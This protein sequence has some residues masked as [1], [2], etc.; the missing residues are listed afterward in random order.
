[1]G[2]K[3]ICIILAVAVFCGVLPF[4][5]FA[6][7][8]DINLV[9]GFEYTVETGEPI[10]QSYGELIIEGLEFNRDNG[11][12]TDSQTAQPTKGSDLWFRAYSG[13]SRI[14]SFD[15]GET[16]AV[17]G[18]EAGFLEDRA[19]DIFA[20][21]YIKIHLSSDGENYECVKEH[22][23]EYS[24][25]QDNKSVRH[26][27]KIPL[28]DIYAARFVR[29]EYSCDGFTYCDEIRVKGK[30]ELSGNEKTPKAKPSISMGG[31]TGD[32]NKYSDIVKLYNGFWAKDPSV[33]VL[34]ESELLPY[35]AYVNK[36]GE[37]LDKMFDGAILLP[38]D[39]VYPSGGRLYKND[40]APAIMSDYQLYIEQTFTSG[41]DLS[42]L[43]K[44]VGKVNDKLESDKKF[45][46]FLSV[47]YPCIT[48]VPFGD[49]NSDGIVDY[50][51]TLEDRLAI[52]K[53]YV[54][55]CISLFNENEYNNL[56]L[57]GF[58]WLEDKVDY[59]YSHHETQLL[60]K[61]N[62]YL[63]E[64]G[65][66]TLSSFGYL[67][68]GFDQWKDFGFDASVMKGEL[69]K[70]DLP[71]EMLPEFSRS[72]YNN[73]MGAEIETGALADYMEGEEAYLQLGNKYESYMYYGRKYGYSGAL[74][75]Y[76][77]DMA[78]GT[79][80]EFCYA[81]KS[82]PKGNYLRRLYDLTHNYINNNYINMPPS[83]S[84]ETQVE[85]LYGDNQ[86]NLDFEIK[87]IDSYTDDITVEF[88]IRPEHGNVVAAASKNKLIYS[89]D[90][91]FEGTDCFTVCVTDG[92]NRSE[93]VMVAVS[94]TKP[95]E[96]EEIIP[97]T[98]SAEP[99]PLG[100]N[101]EIPPWLLVVLL[102]LA[103]AMVGVAV[104]VI[105]KPKKEQND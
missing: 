60:I 99:L 80:Y 81:D 12:L 27:V 53:W 100:I 62:D 57:C 44:V 36:N 29:V 55:E 86:I 92:F 4:S 71:S 10:S 34:T 22:Q 46:V 56:E 102:S 49:V 24:P 93:S 94:V 52:I 14:V 68:A 96:P 11:L 64:K 42:A 51:A 66:K 41:Q 79:L 54:E 2:K 40:N 26:S 5:V 3:I 67:S 76:E 90:N 33:G 78:P 95:Q 75:I 35:V 30:K 70:K 32:I 17:S 9:S 39:G 82:T 45:G 16:S 65:Y 20:P 84:V 15:L 83:I 91:G 37:V 104:A 72:I 31:Y 87:D 58:Y 98:V 47:P 85:I 105:V 19:N 43:N 13:K 28:E 48:D 38:C 21:R 7:G 77:Q 61:A 101:S 23:G 8:E 89:V 25:S 1:M 103:L 59:N 73:C 88:P 69:T 97:P 6:Q 50:S 74:N 18:I 63:S